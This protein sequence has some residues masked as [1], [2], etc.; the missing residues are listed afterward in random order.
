MSVAFVFPGQ[1]SQYVGM[2][3]ELYEEFSV[4]REL[5]DAADEM[6]DFPL[7][8]IAFEGPEERLK[9]TQYTQPAIFIHSIAAFKIL[10]ERGIQPVSVAGHSLGEYSAVVAAGALPF[11]EALKLV[12]LRGK[13]MQASGETNPGTMAAIIGL[14]AEVV[15]EIC[16][17]ASREGLVV[18][19]NFNSPGQVVISGS[20]EGVHRAM[21]LARERKARMVTELSVSGAFHSP[22]MKEAL[23]G[24]ETALNEAPFRD[25]EIPVYT[26]VTAAPIRQADEFRTMLKKQ[27]LSP[28]LWE[29]IV[30]NMIADG[31]NQFYEVGPSRVLCGLSRR[32]ERKVPCLPLGKP[33][34]FEALEE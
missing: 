13:L 16:E 22:L 6:L 27:L 11:E 24:L 14:S 8:Q 15:K 18:P 2:G 3:K 5:F 31:V 21:E 7:K 29:D 32:I 20:V 9:Q 19:A 1:G 28:V 34:D 4:A 23:S 17:E 26:N 12:A 33:E 30:R 25:T 10:Q